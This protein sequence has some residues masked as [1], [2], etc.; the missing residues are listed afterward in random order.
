MILT[1]AL[2]GVPKQIEYYFAARIDFVGQKV[3]PN[4]EAL[5]NLFKFAWHYALLYELHE[6]VRFDAHF[7]LNAVSIEVR[8]VNTVVRVGAG[9]I[10]QER[11]A[12]VRLELRQHEWVFHLDIS[13]IFERVS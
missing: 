4:F 1:K 12:R 9:C 10:S 11:V 3:N 2:S 5:I 8:Y 13:F 6:V 7:K